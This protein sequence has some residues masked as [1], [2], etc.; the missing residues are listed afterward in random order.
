METLTLEKLQSAKSVKY[1]GSTLLPVQFSPEDGDN[2]VW[3]VVT[4]DGRLEGFIQMPDST[5]GRLH[6]GFCGPYDFGNISFSVVQ[7]T[8]EHLEILA[9]F[10]CDVCIVIDGDKYRGDFVLSPKFRTF[11][12]RETS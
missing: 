7:A 2:H 10:F 4:A 5:P 1:K 12:M 11:L 9:S 3:Q 6:R 8:E